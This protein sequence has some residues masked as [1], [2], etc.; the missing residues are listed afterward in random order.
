MSTPTRRSQTGASRQVLAQ[1]AARHIGRP[2]LIRPDAI[3]PLLATLGIGAGGDDLA[4]RRRS[5]LGLGRLFGGAGARQ[6]VQAFYDDD[7]DDDAIAASMDIGEALRPEPVWL[8]ERRVT[9]GGFGY[10]VADGIAVIKV[11]GVLPDEGGMFCGAWHGYDTLTKAVTEAFADA[12]VRGIFLEIDSPGGVVSSR[13]PQLSA[14]IRQGRASG[15]ETGK[16]VWAWAD[17]CCASAAYWIAAAC[18]RIHAGPYSL[19]GSIG[20]VIVHQSVAGWLA[21]EGIEITEIQFGASK[22]DGQWWKALSETARADLQAEVDQVGEDFL[23]E[24]ALGRPALTAD[25][26]RALEARVFLARHRDAGR[27]ALD[28]GLIDQI[29]PDPATAF[30]ALVTS[31]GGSPAP[32]AEEPEMALRTRAA[33]ALSAHKNGRISAATALARINAAL[34]EEGTPAQEETDAADDEDTTTA[35]GADPKET[36]AIDDMDDIDDDEGE[37]DGKAGASASAER[38]RIQAIT[39]APEAKG[40]EALAQHLAFKTRTSAKAAIAMLA[41][42]PKGSRLAGAVD[43]AIGASAPGGVGSGT[44]AGTA[45]AALKAAA[46]KLSGKA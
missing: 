28:L 14:A 44:G 20:A 11:S 45:A 3:Q 34:A 27:A 18:D 1:M 6:P 46:R 38:A 10:V 40:R 12:N 32:A 15:G 13:L 26:I 24:V 5:L 2:V 23:G 43:P 42:A 22:T 8:D 21:R 4:P 9:G 39:T 37:M 30:N 29:D 36:D 31:T 16:P 35:E 33:A 41:A 17:Q 7:D 19:I 25:T